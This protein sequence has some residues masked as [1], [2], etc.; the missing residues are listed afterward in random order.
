[1]SI[2][3]R[4]RS[5]L[6]SICHCE[7]YF[8]GRR[9]CSFVSVRILQVEITIAWEHSTAEGTTLR[10]VTK[11]VIFIH[12]IISIT[13][14][15]IYYTVYTLKRDRCKETFGGSGDRN[16]MGTRFSVLVQTDP[17]AHSASCT[18]G[19]WSVFGVKRPGR[20]VDTHPI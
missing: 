8:G 10:L 17:G 2:R 7:G 16:P 13:Y 9:Y 12:F 6:I 19:T 4:I 15:R 5:N 18:M 3:N 20:G 1:M 14:S 11:C